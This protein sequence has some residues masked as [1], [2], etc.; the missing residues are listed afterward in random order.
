MVGRRLLPWRRGANQIDAL[1]VAIT[2]D[3][4]VG[5]FHVLFRMQVL[6]RPAASFTR[7]DA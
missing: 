2:I 7:T 1:A 6:P 5:S 3:M 4:S